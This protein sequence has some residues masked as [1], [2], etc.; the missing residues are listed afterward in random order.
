MVVI[1]S[2]SVGLLVA[3]TSLSH[4]QSEEL[5]QLGLRHLPESLSQTSPSI[6]LLSDTQ[7]LL[8]P[9]IVGS[10]VGVA[11]GQTHEVSVEHSDFLHFFAVGSQY[12]PDTQ[13]LS[14]I[15]VS[16]Q[17]TGVGVI[18]IV[19]VGVI[20]V[21]IDGVAVVVMDGVVV[22]VTIV[23]VV[24]V[25]VVSGVLVVVPIQPTPCLHVV[26]AAQFVQCQ[27][28]ST[29]PSSAVVNTFSVPSA[30]L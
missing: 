7:P 9:T 12:R 4:L 20:V 8:Q 26:P 19:S 17:D 30:A 15:H 23:V 27:R 16:L 29:L 1:V 22:V 5:I 6:Q 28:K 18:V 11:V 2:L 10:F 21:V 3:V 24:V 25:V 13:S 14:V